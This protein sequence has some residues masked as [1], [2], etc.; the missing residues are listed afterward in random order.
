MTEHDV[1]RGHIECSVEAR[2]GSATVCESIDAGVS[3]KHPVA[4]VDGD[5]TALHRDQRLRKHQR[6]VAP[7]LKFGLTIDGA[8]HSEAMHFVVFEVAFVHRA[9]TPVE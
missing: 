9:V 1:C 8:F 4:A 5:T 6:S 7:L 2:C 3:L